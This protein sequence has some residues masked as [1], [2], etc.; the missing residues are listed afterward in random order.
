MTS[1]VAS[2]VDGDLHGRGVHDGVVGWP[3]KFRRE[4][5]ALD[6][7]AQQLGVQS[8]TGMHP[9]MSAEDVEAADYCGPVG[10]RWCLVQRSVS[11][12]HHLWWCWC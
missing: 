9:G 4:F 10:F 3:Q 2:T 8:V 12:V 5:A 6:G 7:R 1:V 11:D